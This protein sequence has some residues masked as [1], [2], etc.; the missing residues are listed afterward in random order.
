MLV[1]GRDL[2][3]L[4]GEGRE[5]DHQIDRPGM[6]ARNAGPHHFAGIDQPLPLTGGGG[7]AEDLGRRDGRHGGGRKRCQPD[8]FPQ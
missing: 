5:V 1:G 2:R 7:C 6:E 8:D 4:G 3:G